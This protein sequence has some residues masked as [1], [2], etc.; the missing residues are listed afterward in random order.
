MYCEVEM[1]ISFFL[2]LNLLKQINNLLEQSNL[3]I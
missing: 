2:S 1:R 3:K